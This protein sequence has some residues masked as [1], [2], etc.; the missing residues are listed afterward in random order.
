MPFDQ[1]SVHMRWR[2]RQLRSAAWYGEHESSVMPSCA[3]Y[4]RLASCHTTRAN[5]STPLMVSPQSQRM[6]FRRGHL[7]P[8]RLEVMAAHPRAAVT[9]ADVAIRPATVQQVLDGEHD[10]APR[11][12]PRG[13][14]RNVDTI[15]KRTGGAVSP[16]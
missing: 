12:A 2:L 5:Q 11:A 14:T 3:M 16:A 9:R 13:V 15:G 10:R 4:S 1:H 8:D 7:G 6:G